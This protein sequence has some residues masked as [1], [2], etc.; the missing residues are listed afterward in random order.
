M[1]RSP[2]LQP[3]INQC[4]RVKLFY[5]NYPQDITLIMIDLTINNT[6]LNYTGNKGEISYFSD[7]MNTFNNKHCYKIIISDNSTDGLCCVFGYGYF[8]VQWNY[9]IQS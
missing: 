5:D 8:I 3:T 4:F 1:T 9:D 7:C 6:V 2:S